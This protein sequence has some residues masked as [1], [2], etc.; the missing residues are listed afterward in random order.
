MCIRLTASEIP[1]MKSG[2]ASVAHVEDVSTWQLRHKPTD[3]GYHGPQRIIS[4]FLGKD[5]EY[6]C[7]TTTPI[8]A[9][10]T[11]QKPPRIQELTMRHVS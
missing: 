5:A 6:A 8:G 4:A 7:L 2:K 11:H 1:P 9:H 10:L 3:V